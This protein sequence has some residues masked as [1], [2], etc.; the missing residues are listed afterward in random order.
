MTV[1]AVG[2]ADAVP[3]R[4]L[5][6]RALAE[7]PDA[8][9]ATVADELKLTPDDCAQLIGR[10]Q[11]A[12][13]LA[14]YVA[15]A[16]EAWVGM[17]GGRWFDRERG[18]A[19]LWGMWVDPA[20]RGRRLGERLVV[21]VRAWAADHGA[22]FLRLGV[23]SPPGDVIAFYERLGFVRTGEIRPLR[24]DPSRQAVYLVRPV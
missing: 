14:I 1:R 11:V 6:V 24:R 19:Q 17:G 12:D 8:F 16:G 7:S 15:L 2:T 13:E 5:R 21:A 9:G 10:C 18:V 20:V 23:A 3:L 4:A 22:R